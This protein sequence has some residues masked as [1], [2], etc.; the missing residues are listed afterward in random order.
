MSK[1]VLYCESWKGGGAAVAYGS[2]VGSAE[3]Q[4]SLGVKERH[5][6]E[7]GGGRGNSSVGQRCGERQQGK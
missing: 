4:V 7:G 6:G 1:G 5:R 2:A 3:V